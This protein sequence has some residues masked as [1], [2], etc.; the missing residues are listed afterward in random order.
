VE[1]LSGELVA[2]ALHVLLGD[3][4]VTLAD[5]VML[6]DRPVH[7]ESL[8]RLPLASDQMPTGYRSSSSIPVTFSSHSQS[9]SDEP[10]PPIWTA[11]T[12]TTS[13]SDCAHVRSGR[14]GTSM[15]RPDVRS[16]RLRLLTACSSRYR[17]GSEPWLP[18]CRMGPVLS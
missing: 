10:Y 2:E 17:Q 12:A 16:R 11:T 7:D 5:G 4:V 14:S 3:G 6:R 13:T 9:S 18:G 1:R 8:H 15:S